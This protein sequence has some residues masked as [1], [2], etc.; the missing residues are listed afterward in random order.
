MHTTITSLSPQQVFLIQGDSSLC[1][2]VVSE[3]ATA[4]V[5]YEA[6]YL[7]RFTIE[8]AKEVVQ[9]N[10]EHAG[11]PDW[12]VVYT[13]LFISDAAQVLL[14]TLEEPGRD[15]CIVFVTP[16]PYLVPQ[17]IRSRVRLLLG[18]QL[19]ENNAVPE[20]MQSKKVFLDYIKE[21]LGDE[22]TD[23]SERR[24]QATILLDT[25]EHLCKKSPEKVDYVYKA[26]TMLYKANMPTKQVMEYV[27][28]MTL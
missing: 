9:W 8:E 20:Y 26:K 24:A 10:N 5:S 2:L 4:R 23:A 25:L 27:A 14:K 6:R 15:V 3:L 13:T 11:N 22:D 16:H 19:Q 1:E 28:T 12:L 21:V 18:T 17:T 7:S